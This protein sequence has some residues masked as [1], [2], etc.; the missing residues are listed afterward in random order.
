MT[1]SSYP[2]GTTGIILGFILLLIF[3]M[4]IGGQVLAHTKIIRLTVGE[5]VLIST[6]MG[7]LGLFF[8]LAIGQQVLLSIVVFFIFIFFAILLFVRKANR[9]YLERE[10]RKSVS[11]GIQKERY[12]GG[13]E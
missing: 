6:F 10:H 13:R 7:L 11:S 5:V 1:L 2:L 9:W 12:D 3:A 8:G 4:Y